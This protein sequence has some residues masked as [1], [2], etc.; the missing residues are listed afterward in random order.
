MAGFLFGFDIAVI[1]GAILLLRE[2]F[3]LTDFQTEFAASSLLTGCV[4]GASIAGMLSDRFGRRRILIL[5]AIL[6]A[7]SSIG[8]A[9]PRTL[10]QFA[11]ARF[12]GGVAI[13]VASVLAPLYIAEVSPPHIRGRLVS[14]NQMAIVTGILAAYSV[15]WMLAGMGPSSWRWMFASAALP[16][17]AFF[18]ALLFV[19]ES[20]RWLTERLRSVEALQILSRIGGREHAAAELKQIQE[21]IALE[22]GTFRELFRPGLRRPLMIAVAL[23]VLQQITGVNTVLFYGSIIFKEHAGRGSESSAIAANVIVGAINFVATIVALW[24]IDKV[25]RKALLIVSAAGMAVAEISLGTAFL[26]HP[27]PSTFILA[28]VL[29]CVACFAVGLGPGVWVL[30]SELFPT[31]LRGRAMSVATI[32]LWTACLGLTLSFLSLVHAITVT[33]AFW[34]YAAMCVATVVL[35]WRTVPE[36]KG[37]SLEEIERLWI[38]EGKREA[39]EN[40][41]G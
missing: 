24:V 17:A 19:P 16:S 18:A 2:Q 9:L 31:R 4:A 14:L 21:A 10:A 29:L 41:C 37:K 13:G 8:A 22:K 6:F 25:G 30:L 34:T 28:I 11:G 20:P 26:M 36:T 5:S 12:C 27:P 15:N 7:V 40:R 23:A 38:G 33:G 32:S 1:N 39:A 3:R 35:V